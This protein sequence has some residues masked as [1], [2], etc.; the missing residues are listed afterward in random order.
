M[1]EELEQQTRVIVP[2]EA[3]SLRVDKNRWLIVASPMEAEP[4]QPNT[5]AQD[6][7]DTQTQ[8]DGLAE[9]M[10]AKERT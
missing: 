6:E 1:T 5:I 2:G 10:R 3:I 8:N 7:E 4:E 9:N